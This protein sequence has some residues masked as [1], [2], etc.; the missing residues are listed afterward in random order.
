MRLIVSHR[1]YHIAERY[2][3]FLLAVTFH[4]F[5]FHVATSKEIRNCRENQVEIWIFIPFFLGFSLKQTLRAKF[6][7]T[8]VNV[9]IKLHECAIFSA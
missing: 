9:L 4:L 7:V 5:Y 2:P 6:V 1:P 3:R 8:C